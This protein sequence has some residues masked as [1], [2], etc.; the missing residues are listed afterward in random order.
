MERLVEVREL[1]LRWTIVSK[2]AWI[3]PRDRGRLMFPNKQSRCTQRVSVTSS[4]FVL[5]AVLVSAD[6]VTPPTIGL[7]QNKF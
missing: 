1:F 7:F 2:D 5:C 6:P 4:R 3:Q